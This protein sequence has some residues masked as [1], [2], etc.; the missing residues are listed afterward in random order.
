MIEHLSPGIR[1]EVE[2][3]WL[4][5]PGFVQNF[6]ARVQEV[7]AEADAGLD[8]L[9]EQHALDQGPMGAAFGVLQSRIQGLSTK[10]DEA[11]TKIEEHLWEILFRDDIS[12]QDS[13][14]LSRLHDDICRQ[15]R[16]QEEALEMTHE[17]L[18]TRKNA[19]WARKLAEHAQNEAGEGLKCSN[20]GSA[21]ALKVTWQATNE[22]CPHCDAV[23]S[24]SPGAASYAYFGQGVHA[25]AHE[26]AFEEWKNEQHAKATF[27][28]FRHP[29]AYDHWQYLQAAR[30]YWTRYYQ[31]TQQMHPGFLTS[32]GSVEAAAENKLKHYTAHDPVV[33]QQQR[34]FFGRVLDA[35]RRQDDPGVRQLLASMPDGV[36]LD[37]C[38]EAAMERQDQ[39]AAQLIL[40]IKYDVEGED[41][42]REAWLREQLRDVWET[43]RDQ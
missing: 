29:T 22:T 17:A 8:Q 28:R 36:D 40:N 34:D 6:N 39:Q 37:E 4:K 31:S 19:Q 7:V 1:Q 10:I 25:L 18:Q 12:P 21:F 33:D 35:A 32:H 27:D 2:P 24:V 42:P 9:I 13:D 14:I 3:L 20:C 15:H 26:Q 30:A 38:A 43:V 5:W 11:A 16:Q 41:E 23:N